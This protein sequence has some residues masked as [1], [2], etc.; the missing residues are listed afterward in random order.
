VEGAEQRVVD[1]DT[2]MNE[3]R[4]SVDMFLERWG[5]NNPSWNIDVDIIS[6][7]DDP[8]HNGEI[9]CDHTIGSYPPWVD[10]EW[11]DRHRRLNSDGSLSLRLYYGIDR[12][13]DAGHDDG[14]HEIFSSMSVTL[15]W[16]PGRSQVTSHGNP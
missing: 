11:F 3:P 7:D 12:D 15:T 6:V 10:P 16:C 2:I 5:P 1:L 9:R 14:H 4:S 13:E 8:Y